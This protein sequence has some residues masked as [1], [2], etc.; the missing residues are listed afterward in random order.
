MKKS[1]EID[2]QMVS[3]RVEDGIGYICID[4]ANESVN[5]LSPAMSGRMD[6]I[7][8][9]LRREPK[10][11][12][13]VIHSAK[14]DFIVGFDIKELKRYTQNPEGLDALVSQGHALMGKFESLGVPFVS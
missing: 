7:L 13:A 9:D 3:L 4:V 14:K 8:E 12:G 11:V 2:D 10:L 6:E 1:K 5:T